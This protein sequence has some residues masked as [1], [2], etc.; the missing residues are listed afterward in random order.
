MTICLKSFCQKPKSHNVNFSNSTK[1]ETF[2]KQSYTR[3]HNSKHYTPTMFATNTPT[4]VIHSFASL[5]H[6][7]TNTTLHPLHIHLHKN[8]LTQASAHT[9]AIHTHF[10]SHGLTNACTRDTLDQFDS[11]CFDALKPAKRPLPFQ[12]CRQLFGEKLAGVNVM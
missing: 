9:H 4:T 2:C 12:F 3:S 1:V 8:T 5:S 10:C 11:H 7:H 6:T